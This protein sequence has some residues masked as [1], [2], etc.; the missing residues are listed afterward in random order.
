MLQGAVNLPESDYFAERATGN[1]FNNQ[2]F[3]PPRCTKQIPRLPEYGKQ[4]LTQT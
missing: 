4:L 2:M 1:I 3:A